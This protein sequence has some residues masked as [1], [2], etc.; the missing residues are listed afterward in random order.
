MTEARSPD[1]AVSGRDA[2]RSA[3]ASCA[4]T[5]TTPAVLGAAGET[6]GRRVL[7]FL[8]NAPSRLA[9]VVLFALMVMTFFDVVLRSTINNPIE[10]ATELTRLALAIIVFSSLPAVSFKGEHII[11]DLMEGFMRPWLRRALD[12]IINVACGVALF[13]PAIRV[14]QL[15]ARAK[16][17]GDMTEYLHI[18]QFY[19]SY[20]IAIMTFAAAIAFIARGLAMFFRPG[21]IHPYRSPDNPAYTPPED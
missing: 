21:L 6:S 11:V 1:Q 16:E 19:I 3:A 12:L 9:G 10:S 20:F 8:G 5:R 13:W 15:A 4:G 7:R 18:P 17:Y 2:S 14:W